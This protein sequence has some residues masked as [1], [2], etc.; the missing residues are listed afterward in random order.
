M[1]PS[2]KL[3]TR[4]SVRLSGFHYQTMAHWNFKHWKSVI[5]MN[6]EWLTCCKSEE[7]A[8]KVQGVT[9]SESG[10]SVVNRDGRHAALPYRDS[11]FSVIYLQ[12]RPNKAMN[13]KSTNLE[14]FAEETKFFGRPGSCIGLYQCC[15]SNSSEKSHYATLLSPI[16]DFW[17]SFNFYHDQ[18][19]TQNDH[20]YVCDQV[21]LGNTRIANK[22]QMLSETFEKS[23]ENG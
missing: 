2:T 11:F 10:G 22:A 6:L 20:T 19:P 12:K 13:T 23:L 14:T 16:G 7:I 4:I 15:Q 8:E 1:W 3:S 18:S 9:F 5:W 17:I 21:S